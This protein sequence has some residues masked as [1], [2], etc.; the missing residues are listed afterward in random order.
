[1]FLY[2]WWVAN[3]GSSFCPLINCGHC[4]WSKRVPLLLP[5]WDNNLATGHYIKDKAKNIWFIKEGTKPGISPSLVSF[6]SSDPSAIGSF[7]RALH[8]LVLFLVLHVMFQVRPSSRWWLSRLPQSVCYTVSLIALRVYSL[9]FERTVRVVPA[10]LLHI[11]DFKF[12]W[13]LWSFARIWS[14]LSDFLMCL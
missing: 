6:A 9:V 10:L 4:H 13:S 12:L 1:M 11:V 7:S 8:L 2:F 5:V 3:Y 14:L